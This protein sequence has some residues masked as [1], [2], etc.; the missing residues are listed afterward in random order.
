[1]KTTTLVPLNRR[2]RVLKKVRQH[3][4]E[5]PLVLNQVPDSLT[6]LLNALPLA[7]TAL[8]SQIVPRLG[9]TGDERVLEPLLGLIVE[10]EIDESV[11]RLAALQLSLAA[12][13]SDDS[14]ALVEALIGNLDHPHPSVRANCALALGWRNHRSAVK[15]LL[16]HLDDPDRDVGE[17]V[18]AALT[19]VGTRAVFDLL[20]ARLKTG[21]LDMR[22]CI[23]LNLWRFERPAARVV[24]TYLK[25]MAV[26]PVALRLDALCGLGMLPLSKNLLRG[27]GQLLSDEDPQVRAQVIENLKVLPPRDY[28]SLWD[29]LEPLLSDTDN[30]VRQAAIRLFAKR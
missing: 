25:S 13:A 21:S 29:C 24:S 8:L 17:A 5:S 10:D 23:L 6:L 26:L 30:R 16:A 18:V 22:R 2:N 4:V 19:A 20:T 3:L 28:R 27:Y 9:L 7:D 14:Q 1:M 12:A 11:R 15:P